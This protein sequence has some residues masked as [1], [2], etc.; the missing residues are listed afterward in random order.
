VFSVIQK[1]RFH[2]SNIYSA[3]PMPFMQRITWSGVAL[4]AGVVPGYPA[5]HGCIRLTPGFATELW[6]MT[7]VGARVVIAPDDVPAHELAHAALPVP[8]MTPAPETVAAAGE[9]VLLKAALT[10]GAVSAPAS[11]PNP[12]PPPPRLLNPLERAQAAKVSTAADAI[13]KAKATKEAA[14]H[15]S[16]LTAEANKAIAA[17][18]KAERAVAA[19]RARLDAA[20][21]VVEEAKGPEALEK[22]IAGEA[23]AKAALDAAEKDAADAAKEENA[24]T[25]AAFNAARAAWEAEDASKQA[26]AAKEA[27]EHGV[28]P[29]SIFISRKTGRIYI[30]Q[31]WL[32]VY[33]APVTFKEPGLP[34]GTHLYLATEAL[35]NGKALRWLSAS[36]APTPPKAEARRR[37]DRDERPAAAPQ[38]AAATPHLTAAQAL[39]MVELPAEARAFIEER[40]WTGAALIVSDHGISDETGKYTDFIVLTR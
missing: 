4:H 28:E 29:L 19:A 25:F 3:A 15:S 1:Q 36:M 6:G 10:T 22:A 18:G 30:R 12:S 23:A 27:A 26:A 2:R 38:A 9:E 34:L 24:K 32:P 35:E 14:Q 31:D 40:L 16:L 7:K 33:E 13:A 17:L 20:A 39:D 37:G 21:K 8:L 5:S 11:S